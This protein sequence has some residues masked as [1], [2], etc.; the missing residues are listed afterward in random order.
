MQVNKKS[1]GKR[2]KKEKTSLSK[3]LTG[4]IVQDPAFRI[5]QP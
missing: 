5:D 4:W 1:V 3:K 2:K